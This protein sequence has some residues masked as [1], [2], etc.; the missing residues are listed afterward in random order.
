MDRTCLNVTKL[1]T[2]L[3]VEFKTPVL[4][5][6]AFDE[7]NSVL[8]TIDDTVTGVVFTSPLD[9][10]I[11][12][13]GADLY[14]L[15]RLL[16]GEDIEGLR[17]VLTRGQDTFERIESL[18]VPTVATVHGACLGGGFELSLACDHR[19]ASSD[20]C[21]KIGLPEVTLGIL[22]AWGGTVRLSALLPLAD[23]LQVILTGKQYASKPALK[24]GLVDKVVHKENMIN[25]AV[26]LIGAG[27][28]LQRPQPIGWIPSAIIFKSALR[29]TLNKTKGNYPAPETIIEVLQKASQTAMSES[30]KLERDAFMKLCATQE[31]RSLLRIFL[32]Q[33]KSKKLNVN[34]QKY[35]HVRSAAV[36]GAGTM[37]AGITQWLSCKGINVILKDVNSELISK[38]LSHIDKLYVNGVLGHKFDRPTA[39]NGMARI[40]TSVTDIDLHKDLIIEAIVEDLDV[41][42]TVLAELE[43]RSST[44]TIIATNTSAL[45]INDMASCLKRPDKFV[46]IH[47]FNPVHK[48]K[49]VEVVKGKHTSNAT[50]QRA[51]QF[52]QQIGKF[53]VVVN[54]SPGFVVNRIL[55]PY[56]MK[57][58]QLLLEGNQMEAIDSGM[59]KFGMPMGPFRLM[60][61]IGLDV[62]YH[63]ANDLKN[64]LGIESSLEELSWRVGSGKLGKKSSEGF[65]AYKKGKSIRRKMTEKADISDLVDVMS[66]EAQRVLNE[67]VIDDP[68]MLDFAMI[69]GTGWAPFRGGPV[70]YDKSLKALEEERRCAISKQN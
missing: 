69:M 44:N 10:K 30:F 2:I 49:L 59:V 17:A 9:S 55:V 57:A 25:S 6:Q 27:K 12:L 7:L 45:S 22:P 16:K 26:D 39:R 8:D 29:T 32:L 61:E 34:G 46:G 52:V 58:S 4:T 11:F 36:V 24:L 18:S 67:G 37:G 53:P 33:E 23:T 56:L 54:D 68:D 13:A 62:C 41:K 5:A 48:M 40:T 38:G 65:Y 66:L 50:V 51:V 14:E 31:M 21:T 20:R 1:D 47:F 28:P 15:D 63:V 70:N 64:R 3:V 19:I 42:K 43:Q 35:S 60:D